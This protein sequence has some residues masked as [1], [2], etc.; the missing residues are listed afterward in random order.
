MQQYKCSACGY[1]KCDRDF[2]D[3][4]AETPIYSTLGS[5]FIL[6]YYNEVGCKEQE[7]CPN[8]GHACTWVPVEE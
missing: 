8:C 3:I 5:G 7:I 4:I 2:T 6:G 1:R